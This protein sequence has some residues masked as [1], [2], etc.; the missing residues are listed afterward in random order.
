[1]GKQRLRQDADDGGRK[2]HANLF[3]LIGRKHVDNAVHRALGAGGVQR[4]EHDVPGFGRGDGGFDRGQVAHFA[5]QNHVGVLPQGAADG[6][7]EARHV[8]AHFALI[9]R[10]FLVVVIKLDRVFNRDDV[11]IDRCR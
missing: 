5:D 2:L 1:M 8:D 9:D 3:L 11:M 6:F 10:R 7:G 4:A